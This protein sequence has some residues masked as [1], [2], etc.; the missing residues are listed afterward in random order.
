[1]KDGSRF[2]ADLVIA[3][4][5]LGGSSWSVM[6]DQ[7]VSARSSGNAIFRV[8]YP[9]EQAVADSVTEERFKLQDDGRSVL[10][11]WSG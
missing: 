1:M 7:P 2:E 4:D 5:G 11:M 9:V 10:E 8:A 6:S 3:A